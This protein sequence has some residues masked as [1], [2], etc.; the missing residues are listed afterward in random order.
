MAVPEP[1]SHRLVDVYGEAGRDWLHGLGEALRDAAERWSLRLLPPFAG[2]SYAWVAPALRR[3]GEP[4]VLKATVPS[5]AL[6]AEAEALRAF[7]GRG[8]VRLLDADPERGL[9]LL[10]R[11]AP[12]TPLLAVEDDD[13]ATQ[14]AAP[15]LRELPAEP[16]GGAAFPT[17]AD[18]LLGLRRLRNRFGGGTGPFPPDLV[19]T[20]ESLARD[21]LASSPPPRLLHGDL[22][23]TNVLAAGRQPWL[24]ID[25][26]GVLGDPAYEPAAFLR[27]PEPR[28]K[29]A[30]DPG[31]LLAR[32]LDRL[33]AEL[34]CERA[35]LRDWGVVH[36]VL[37]AW[38]T[39]EDH[40]P[41]GDRAPALR[42]AELLRRA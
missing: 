16:P 6:R 1:L 13:R 26:K 32:R 28:L 9:L 31:R 41:A 42:C 3:D 21:L 17:L 19:A 30:P 14:I 27:N 36:S 22:H 29:A 8:A 5:P 12:G 35:R 38:W 4:V 33:A 20:A 37:S 40:G 18:R 7:G 34:P 11:L 23:H 10:E 25:P 24:A 39:F 2:L 15:I